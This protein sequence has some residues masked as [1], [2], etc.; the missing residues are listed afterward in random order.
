MPS[1]PLRPCSVPGCPNAAVR[2]SRCAEHAREV[3]RQG[4]E[5]RASATA[6]GYDQ[7]WRRIRAAFLK[8]HTE[9]A[10]C[11]EPATVADH[12]VPLSQGGGND[13][14]NLQP[15]CVTCHNRKTNR[16]DGGGWGNR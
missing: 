13:W 7:K 11:G 16:Q 3:R 9:C 10:E 14:A 8:R 6:R 4:E 15:L 5:G 1:R 2:G 12:V